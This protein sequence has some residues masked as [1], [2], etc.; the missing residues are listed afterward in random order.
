MA[1]AGALIG[2]H[3]ILPYLN[4]TYY[5]AVDYATLIPACKQLYDDLAN[6]DPDALL[7]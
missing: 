1:I 2:H 3:L 4:L 5:D 6:A 7:G